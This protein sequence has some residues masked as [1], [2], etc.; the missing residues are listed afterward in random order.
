MISTIMDFVESFKMREPDLICWEIL[1]NQKKLRRK[2]LQKITHLIDKVSLIWKAKK[3][4]SA[5]VNM[6][7]PVQSPDKTTFDITVSPQD[8]IVKIV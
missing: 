8:L 6:T 3:T 2:Y 1:H 5:F 7:T 4:Y